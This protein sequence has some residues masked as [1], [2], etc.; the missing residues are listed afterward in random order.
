MEAA[1]KDIK[2]MQEMKSN[3]AVNALQKSNKQNR[4]TET[5]VK[6]TRDACYCCG[7]KG[8]QPQSCRFRE[9][10]C[11]NCRKTGHIAA[12]CRNRIN[13]QKPQ[14]STKA[15][16][17][18]HVQLDSEDDE[19][20]ELS[21]LNGIEERDMQ[22][23]NSK[24]LIKVHINRQPRWMERDT[25]AAVSVIWGIP[26]TSEDSNEKITKAATISYRTDI[27]AGRRS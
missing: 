23:L 12:V 6:P 7:R 17:Q 20:K 1:D 26:K 4:A 8:H 18:K 3:E 16:M 15:N 5:M 9:A 11:H 21:Q 25:G 27:R 24:P 13:P 14:V 19:E 2:T 10:Q 22:L